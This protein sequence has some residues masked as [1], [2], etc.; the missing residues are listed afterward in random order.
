MRE[1]LPLLDFV[2]RLNCDRRSSRVP[3]GGALVH[4]GDAQQ[5]LFLERR[6]QDCRPI[7]R[8]LFVKPHGMLMPG[9]AR[10]V[11]S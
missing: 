1:L 10:E 2:S 5:L 6:R 11:G 3:V 7:G 8:P 9:D 4:A